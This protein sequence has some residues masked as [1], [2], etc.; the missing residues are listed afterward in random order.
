MIYTKCQSI[1]IHHPVTLSLLQKLII[2]ANKSDNNQNG[3]YLRCCV[4]SIGRTSSAWFIDLMYK[5]IIFV[6][7]ICMN[8]HV[9][10]DTRRPTEN[11]QKLK[12]YKRKFGNIDNE[13]NQNLNRKMAQF[14]SSI[15][16]ITNKIKIF[17]KNYIENDIIYCREF[18]LRPIDR[19][20][21]NHTNQ[22]VYSQR[23]ED[24]LYEYHKGFS[25]GKYCITYFAH[26]FKHEMLINNDGTLKCTVNI[27]MHTK[28]E[29][30]KEE[31]IGYLAQ[32]G[33][34]CLEYRVILSSAQTI[35]KILV[36]KI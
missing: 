34:V 7:C 29:N 33:T 16:I 13:H 11:C 12:D 5:D 17:N 9:N 27:L 30:D 32:N 15:D 35:K 20:W 4:G 8:V 21:N 10:P 26:F 1:T 25:N 14:R 28:I 19:D 36:S 3:L 31:I 23:I 6:S 2:D 22:A 24:S 18:E